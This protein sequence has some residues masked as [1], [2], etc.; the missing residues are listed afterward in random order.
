MTDVDV[1][2][3]FFFCLE[4]SRRD[5]KFYFSLMWYHSCLLYPLA[6]EH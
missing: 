5:R 1:I 2:V 6:I 3:L 4:A